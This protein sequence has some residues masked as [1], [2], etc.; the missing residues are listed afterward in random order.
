[1]NGRGNCSK[2]IWISFFHLLSKCNGSFVVLGVWIPDAPGDVRHLESCPMFRLGA[3]VA[4]KGLHEDVFSDVDDLGHVG[5]LFGYHGLEGAQTIAL[6]TRG[7][8]QRSRVCII[9]CSNSSRKP[10]I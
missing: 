9:P 1:M 6:V 8:G 4:T 5:L 2:D 10:S 3:L 7:V